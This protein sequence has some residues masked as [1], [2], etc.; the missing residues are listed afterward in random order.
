MILKLIFM[1]AILVLISLQ[2]PWFSLYRKYISANNSTIFRYI[3]TSTLF[4]KSHDIL[5]VLNINYPRTF[6]P[7]SPTFLF[8]LVSRICQTP[9][10]QQK[11]PTNSA[12]THSATATG[13]S[14]PLAPPAVTVC[15]R[16]ST[17]WLTSWRTRSEAN[18]WTTE[19]QLIREHQWGFF[20]CVYKM[21]TKRAGGLAALPVLFTNL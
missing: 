9:W 15:T 2:Y 5:F 7:V 11:S 18:L 14:R 6:T 12:S 8:T 3:T 16:A 4:P 1:W 19:L 17:G 20:Y 13:T 10:M 21:R